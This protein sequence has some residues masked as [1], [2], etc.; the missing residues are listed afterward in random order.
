MIALLLLTLVGVRMLVW[1]ATRLFGGV[2]V[3]GD[4]LGTTNEI[5]EIVFLFSAPLLIAVA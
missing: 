5:T 1:C 3:T 4:I 2:G